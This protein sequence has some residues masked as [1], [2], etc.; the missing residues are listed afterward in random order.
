M[1]EADMDI[2]EIVAGIGS[3]DALRGVAERVGLSPDQAQGA[4]Q[5]VIEHV[6]AGRP[7][8]GMVEGVAAKVGAA[9]DQ[10]QQ[11]LPNVM[12]LLQ[13]HAENASEGVQGMLGGLMGSLQ[14]SPAASLLGHGEGEAG[15]VLQ[16][17]AGGLFGKH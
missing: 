12:G 15:S 7:L 3:S 2:Q 4:L 5:G 10:V 9:P 16:G 14:N 8:E 13:G 17:L 6:T 1:Q 11:L